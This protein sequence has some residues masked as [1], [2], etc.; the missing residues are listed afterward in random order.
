MMLDEIDTENASIAKPIAMPMIET[1]S[2]KYSRGMLV[3]CKRNY[4]LISGRYRLNRGLTTIALV[5]RELLLRFSPLTLS[6]EY[7]F[8]S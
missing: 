7:W 4:L 6:N 8:V 5:S 3:I 2:R 1:I